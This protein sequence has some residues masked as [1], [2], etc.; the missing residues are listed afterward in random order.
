MLL[1]EQGWAGLMLLYEQGWACREV[2]GGEE[3]T[4]MC[5][6]ARLM[7]FLYFSNALACGV[8]EILPNTKTINMFC[9]H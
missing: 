4:V 5:V 8:Y 9:F 1:P 7:I 3:T 2:E 6:T